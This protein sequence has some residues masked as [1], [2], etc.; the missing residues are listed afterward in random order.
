[1]IT[2]LI[3]T[4]NRPDFLIRQLHY[5]RDIGFRGN[6][7]IGDS[8]EPENIQKA[9]ETIKELR[10]SLNINYQECP[11]LSDSQCLKQL[12]IFVETPYVAFVADD[13]ILIPAAMEHCMRFL[14]AHPDYSAAHGTSIT[15]DLKSSGAYGRVSRVRKYRQPVLEADSASQR[16]TEHLGNYQVT[17]F[18]VHCTETWKKMYENIS[19][20]PDRTF[21]GE[22]LP[23]CST[24]I[25]GKVKELDCLYLIRQDH[26][27]RY[28]LPGPDKWISNPDWLS[29]YQTFC[30]ILADELAAQDGITTGKAH[31][32]I[33]QGFESYIVKIAGKKWRSRIGKAENRV[34]L[35]FRQVARKIPGA[36]L[37]WHLLHMTNTEKN[38]EIPLAEFFR[39]SSPYYQDFQ[40]VNQI[41][42]GKSE[43][44][45]HA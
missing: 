38:A 16:I 11:G 45:L 5:Y 13:D 44:R 25:Q 22:M 24:V 42:I 8:S 15:I 41:L 12:I 9:K 33:E 2:L 34:S 31:E 35:K 14:E 1:M 36:Y 21:A 10:D 20:I 39:E 40:A 29:W 27:Q 30:D 28:L 3:P 17:L 18:S 32:I 6:I 7:C 43:E 4:I 26:P 19:L 37:V 23:C